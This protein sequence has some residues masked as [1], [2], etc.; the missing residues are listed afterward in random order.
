MLGSIISHYQI[1]KKL[2]AGGMG[3]VYLAYDKNLDRHVALK[4]LPAEFVSNHDRMRRFT[5]EAKAA[6]AISHPNVAHIY[7]IGAEN[8]VHFIA[9]EYV[10]G[11]TLASRMQ[12]SP[13]DRNEILQIA[14]QIADALQEA[15]GKGI[16]HRDIKP[17][18]I[19]LTSRGKVK[20][21]D[22]GL[23]KVHQQDES[24]ASRVSTASQTELGVAMGTLPYM[25]PE[26]LLGKS[27]DHRTD[28]F[29]VGVVL[30]ELFTQ[31]LPFPGNSSVEMADAILHNAPSALHEVPSQFQPVISKL[32]A[33]DPSAR[34]Q[35]GDDLLAELQKLQTTE[36]AH[37]SWLRRPALLIPLILILSGAG[38]LVFRA[39]QKDKKTEWAREVALLK[40]TELIDEGKNDE[41][42]NLALQAEKYIPNDPLLKNLWPGMSTKMSIKTEPPGANVFY[43]KYESPA[44]PWTFL[45]ESPVQDKRISKGYF[46]WKIQKDGYPEILALLPR[47]FFESEVSLHYKLD[48]YKKT[49]PGMTHVPGASSDPTALR[50]SD[51]LP[52][53]DDFYM[54]QYEVTNQEFKKFVDAGGYGNRNFWKIPFVK[55]G[56]SLTFEEAVALFV[57]ATG[58]PGP[59]DWEVGNFAPGQ[60]NFPV[61]GIS[62]YEAAAYA[63]FAG[64]ALPTIFHWFHASGTRINHVMIPFSNFRG[65]GP[66]PAGK[67]E[68][69]SLYGTFDMAGNVKEWCWNDIADGR[70]VNIGGSYLEPEYL[71]LEPDRRDPFTRHKTIGFRCIQYLRPPAPALLGSYHTDFRDYT[72]EKPV[73][74]SVYA[75]LKTFY[76]Y[77]K[78]PLDSRVESKEQLSYLKKE[79]VSFSAAYG[80]ERVIAYVFLPMNSKPPYQTVLYFPGSWAQYFDSSE[81]LGER[82]EHLDFLVRSGRAVVHPVYSQTLER[83]GRPD[84]D[85]RSTEELRE[86]RIEYIKDVRRTIDYLET[87]GDID[88]QKIAYYGY[89][90]GARVGAIAGAVEPRLRAMI[91]A[92]GGLPMSPRAPE[93]DEINFITRVKAPVLMINGRYDHVFPV[94]TSQNP[95]FQLLGTPEKDKSR[96]IFEGGHS[97]PRSEVKKIMLDWLDRYLGKPE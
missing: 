12:R 49:Q 5:R 86:W 11:E 16:I 27:I 3:E 89:S 57:D 96:L 48:D 37:F 93:T 10:E 94:Q 25:S 66:H 14:V 65:R 26:Q 2:G 41:A 8:N 68:S 67:Q 24:F 1:E 22:F 30:Y 7:E 6:S 38:F 56:K 31:K 44:A 46:R 54:D 28:F 71:F 64:K 42:L 77:D 59:L 84:A 95:F 21:V 9:M 78:K 60:E 36:P 15:H 58:R 81:K 13:L 47:T 39:L 18:N 70:R 53:E 43:K 79:K 61:T 51:S 20:L 34:F 4:I 17:A 82:G 75:V 62:W 32:L 45:G 40:I 85:N 52:I 33:K 72:K 92:H 80:K 97:N 19:I 90:W 73:E 74:D 23:A 50:A 29:S 76:S 63:E 35:R 69:M 83:G 88:S 55:D 87:R 91:L